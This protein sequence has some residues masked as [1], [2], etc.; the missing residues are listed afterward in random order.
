MSDVNAHIGVQIDTSAALAELKALQKQ[1]SLFH[2]SIA[3]SSTAAGLAQR[4]LQANL[5]G[6]INDTGKFV[7]RMG[8]IRTS[9]ESFT[10]AL[11]TN[12]F[13]MGQYFRYAG[14]STKTFGKLFKTEFDTIGRVA[15]ERVKKLQT[16]YIKMGRDSSGAMRAMSITPTTLN[17]K[18]L[19]TQT[20]IAAQKQALFNQLVRQGSTSLLNFGKNTQWAGR[21]LMVGF[22]VPLLY[23]GAAASKT[24]MQIEEQAVKFKRVYGDMFTTTAETGK[25]LADIQMLAKE[26]TKYGIA[27]SKTMEMAATAAATG[28]TGADLIAQVKES[29]RLAVLGGI[30][31]EQS[32]NTIIALTSTFGIEADNLAASI[33]FLNSV[34]NQTILSIEDLTIAI[35]KAGP[36]V[37]QL[38]GD[39]KDLAFFLTAM[40]EG[41]INASEGANALKSGLAAMIN[42]TKKASEMLSGFGINIKAIVEGNAGNLKE[43]VL[44]FAQALDTLK[45]LDR[46]RTI[47]QIFG[48]FQFARISTLFQNIVKEGTQAQQVLEL[49]NSSVEELAILSERELA[50]IE[51]SP[52]FKFKKSVEDLKLTLVPIGGEFLKAITPIAQFLAKFLEK[53]NG[54]SDGS[55]KFIVVMTTLVGVIGPALLMTFGLVANGVANI[56]K[57]FLALRTGFLGITSSSSVLAEQTRYLNTAQMDA[58][59]VAASLN[60]SHSRLA[61]T[62]TMEASAVTA[63]R[64]AYVQATIAA[65]AFARANPGMM[66]PR[67]KAP[68]KF[69]QGTARVRGYATGT[70]SVPAMLTP[71][72][73]VIPAK[74][75]QANP[76]LMQALVDGTIDRFALGTTSVGMRFKSPGVKQSLARQQAKMQSVQTM[77]NVDRAMRSSRFANT[78]P[79]PYGRLISPSTG[80]SFPVS[81]IGGIREKIDGSKVFVKPVLDEK[82]AL[83][84][85]RGTQ[86]ARDVHGLDSPKQT[87]RTM[88]D[89]T[90]PYGKRKLLVL[91]SPVSSKFANATSGFT[92]GQYVKQLVAALLRGDKDLSRSNL[93]GK[94]LADVGPAGVFGKASG[95]R[96][97]EKLPGMQDQAMLSLGAVKA[98]GFNKDFSV[99]TADIARSMSPG[100]FEKAMLKEIDTALPKLKKTIESFGLN[101]QEKIVYQDMVARLQ[102]GRGADWKKIHKVASMVQRPVQKFADGTTSVGGGRNKG[103]SQIAFSHITGDSSTGKS[104]SRTISQLIK[105][106]AFSGETL[107][108]LQGYEASGMGNL[109]TN[110][111]TSLGFDIDKEINQQLQK[112]EVSKKLYLSQISRPGAISTMVEGL[113]IGGA[114]ERQAIRVAE[115]FRS[116]YIEN[117][118]SAPT[119]SVS[120]RFLMGQTDDVL[121]TNKHLMIQNQLSKLDTTMAPKTGSVNK[122]LQQQS[123]S[124]QAELPAKDAIQVLKREGLD[125]GKVLGPRLV[126]EQSTVSVYRDS[127]GKAL[128]IEVRDAKGK[129]SHVGANLEGSLNVVRSKGSERLGGVYR[130]IKS[131]LRMLSAENLGHRTM[132]EAKAAAKANKASRLVALSAGEGVAV[133]GN[134]PV[135]VTKQNTTALPKNVIPFPKNVSDNRLARISNMARVFPRGGMLKVP[136][137]NDGLEPLVGQT[138]GVRN[139]PFSDGAKSTTISQSQL[140]AS[141]ALTENIKATEAGTKSTRN[142]SGKMTAASGMIAMGTMAASFLPGAIGKFA[143]TLMAPAMILSAVAMMGPALL[144]GLKKLSL[145]LISNPLAMVAALFV[146]MAVSIK[147]MIARNT[148]QAKAQVDYINA[149]S[150]STEKMKKVGALTGKVG[151]SEIMA[152]RREGGSSTKFTT[153]YDRAGQQFGATFLDSDVGKSIY[154]TFKTGLSKGGTDAVKNISLELSAYVSD[155]LMSAEDANSVA[156]SIGINMSD[157][158]I[159]ANIRGELRSLIGPDGQDLLTDP[160]NVRINIGKEQAKLGKESLK[161]LQDAGNITLQT[162]FGASVQAANTK[163]L[164]ITQAQ[165][166]AQAVMYDNQLRA[167]EAEKAKTKDKTKQLAIEEKIKVITGKKNSDDEKFGIQKQKLIKDQLK[168]FK[169]TEGKGGFLQLNQTQDAF[170][171]SGKQQVRTKFKNTGQEGFINEFLTKSSETGGRKTSQIEVILNTMVG[172]GDLT[173]LAGTK[174]LNLFGKKGEEK[175]Q[176]ILETTFVTKDPGKIS[177]LVNLVTGI[178]GKGGKEVGLKILTEMAIAK[179]EDKF[180]DRLAALTLLQNMEIKEINIAVVLKDGVKVLDEIF[181][182]LNKVEKIKG[183]I[184]LKI[185]QDL[186]KDPNMP[187]MSAL[188]ADWEHYKYLPDEIK[189]TAIQT[190]ISIYKTIED[191]L[192]SEADRRGLKGP[193]AAA[194]IKREKALSSATLTKKQYAKGKKPNTIPDKE[195]DYDPGSR[196]TTLDNILNRLKMVRDASINATGGMKELMRILS[197][198]K[199]LKVFRG[200]DQQLTNMYDGTKEFIDSVGGMEKAIQKNFISI[201]KT[202]KVVL[203]DKGKALKKAYDEAILGEYAASVTSAIASTI[204]QREEFVRLKAAGADSAMAIEMLSDSEFSFALS[205]AKTSGE[206]KELIKDYLALKKVRDEVSRQQDPI[207]YAQKNFDNIMSKATKAFS[208]QRAAAERAAKPDIAKASEGVRASQKALT[209]VQ[210]DVQ[211]IQDE[212][213]GIQTTIDLKQRELEINVTRVIEGYQNKIDAIQEQMDINFNKPI[214]ALQELSS[215]FSHDLDLINKSAEAIN[216]KYALQEEALTKI[217]EINQDLIAQEKTRI[218]LADALSQGDISAAAQIAQDIRAAAA[219]KA[220]GRASGVLQTARDAEIGGL[221]SATGLTKDQIEE[222]QYAIS[223]QI[224]ALEQGRKVLQADILRIE[225][226]SI[227]PL[228]KKKILDGIIILGLEDDIYKRTQDSLIPAQAAVDIAQDNLDVAQ[229]LLDLYEELLKDILDGIEAQQDQFIAIQEGLDNAE[230]AGFDFT[231]ELKRATTAAIALAAAIHS[232]AL[233]KLALAQAEAD[234]ANKDASGNLGTG[235]DALRDQKIADAKN[236]AV[237]EAKKELEELAAIVTPSAIVTGSGGGGGGGGGRFNFKYLANGGKVGSDTIPAMLTPGEFVMNKMSTKTFGPLL[238]LMN[239]SAY[240]SFGGNSLKGSMSQ[241]SYKPMNITSI[242]PTSNNASTSVNNNSSSVYNYSVGITV[243]GTNSSPDNIAKAVLNEIKYLDSQRIRGQRA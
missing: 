66:N 148:K 9:A 147:L 227:A 139:I 201:N 157:M 163:A 2:Q 86:I 228:N 107:K 205:S 238:E 138:G 49:T 239:N 63:L 89:P 186:E 80:H 123:S 113:K 224:Y 171:Q 235:K 173:P 145:V 211:D 10:N 203:T 184:T 232:V 114:T 4:N 135:K 59:A 127:A 169:Y 21:Q 45:P 144:K 188:V 106:G 97:Y 141:K 82:A 180:D 64:N 65:S 133:P 210:K 36:V 196:D 103:N 109:K 236:A 178:K 215:A 16:Q 69:S 122:F 129:I 194:F 101:P 50:R 230:A 28:K 29:T 151:A 217:S 209:T 11:E 241:S 220:A 58:A 52:M 231:E 70:D 177:E 212:I 91:E 74:T 119:N 131:S 19:S 214:D 98:R 202:G 54:L 130:S 44:D 27:V 124:V 174:L 38:G 115:Q 60:Q 156:R 3:K 73:A 207:G 143:Q 42:P 102:A 17:M 87:I 111:Y 46:A 159:A 68:K 33:D 12:K 8:T 112:G 72:E 142:L 13:S 5:M 76:E 34:E 193:A 243:G 26:F 208:A 223:Q 140:Q 170:M 183:P 242:N 118:K 225:E 168:A 213:S 51:D 57:L 48:K 195:K 23:I 84:E 126:A 162:Q 61:Q 198:T 222:K 229:E 187:D 14:A 167:L 120:D 40:R 121:K 32:L 83:A 41:G 134:R 47:E 175:L 182:L 81:G 166:D 125:I 158:T 192:R 20:A 219:A 53:F 165:G 116:A 95:L 39:V 189:K 146:L 88:L 179:D 99:K 154:E 206:I 108:L 67:F 90:D 31:Q 62:F 79:T 100:Q 218:S 132:G 37:Q 181:P 105:G 234:V 43:T 149:I 78:A 240:P 197:G 96:D 128:G 71:G 153:G 1:L 7:A 191:E 226:F 75:A 152:R 110:A 92:K 190:Y 22:T 55:K 93:Y 160:L 164:E 15:G 172:A 77:I 6:S 30:E 56:I 185:I 216:D 104:H 18:E 176:T 35:P 221:R 161:S 117:L 137:A 25:A 94:V 85:V 150:A 136:G 237:A 155:G 204:R 199:D 200:V 233:E 24:F